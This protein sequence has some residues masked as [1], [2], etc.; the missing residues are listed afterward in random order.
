MNVGGR[1]SLLYSTVDFIFIFVSFFFLICRAISAYIPTSF[2]I[3][4]YSLFLFISF[5]FPLLFNIC[6]TNLNDPEEDLHKPILPG[7]NSCV[8][9]HWFF[10]DIIYQFFSCFLLFFSSNFLDQNNYWKLKTF[11]SLFFLQFILH[12]FT[13]KKIIFTITKLQK[14]IIQISL[15]KM[16][17][18]INTI[19]K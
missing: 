16:K 4:F 3:F 7:S 9:L 2:R 18:K 13:K 10:I 8:F 17:N 5:F 12:L 19:K 1:S 14:L 11:V 6:A 15:Y